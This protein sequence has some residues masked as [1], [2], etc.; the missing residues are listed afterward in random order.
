MNRFLGENENITKPGLQEVGA[1]APQTSSLESVWSTSFCFLHFG[2]PLSGFS[3]VVI[4]LPYIGRAKYLFI[5]HF[6]WIQYCF[7]SDKWLGLS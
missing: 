3:L 1:A 5:I 7:C 4:V 6:P 2:W